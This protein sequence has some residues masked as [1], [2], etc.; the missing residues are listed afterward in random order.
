MVQVDEVKTTYAIFGQ[1][2]QKTDLL[3]S[4]EKTCTDD[5]GTLIFL[6]QGDNEVM[7]PAEFEKIIKT[8]AKA[9]LS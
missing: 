1:G 2:S 8:W 3:I 6:K 7:F 9:E 4:I 5:Y